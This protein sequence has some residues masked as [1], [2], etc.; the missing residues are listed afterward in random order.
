VL[1]PIR[2]TGTFILSISVTSRLAIDGLS[3]Y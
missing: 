3:A 2:S 1:P